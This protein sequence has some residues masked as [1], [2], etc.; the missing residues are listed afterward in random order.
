MSVNSP[1]YL[2][3][4]GWKK[5]EAEDSVVFE[6]SCCLL[7]YLNNERNKANRAW[8]PVSTRSI[9]QADWIL[10][11][12]CAVC[13]KWMP[14]RCRCTPPTEGLSRTA[15]RTLIQSTQ[16]ERK[17]IVAAVARM[18]ANDRMV[19]APVSPAASGPRTP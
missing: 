19:R 7:R 5:A 3:K 10:C 6:C 13:D 14:V 4:N 12:E 1:S 9:H 11:E 16:K 8:I 2:T 18:N 15:R 17:K